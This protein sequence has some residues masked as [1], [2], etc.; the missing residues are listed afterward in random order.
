MARALRQLVDNGIYHVT[1]RGNRREAIFLRDADY[2][3][4]LT[5]YAKLITEHEIHSIAFAL[6]PN[7]V[8]LVLQDPR[9]Q[10]PNFI[11]D[12]HS[13][14]SQYL[15]TQH[16][17][18]GHVFQG[19]YYSGLC[20]SQEQLLTLLRYVHLNPVRAQLVSH[21]CDYPWSSM[22]YYISPHRQTFIRA[23]ILEIF[24]WPHTSA[25][26]AFLD[27]TM[28][29]MDSPQQRLHDEISTVKAGISPHL[30]QSLT[31]IAR[32]IARQHG[33]DFGRIEAKDRTRGVSDER[34]QLIRALHQLQLFSIREIGA[35]LGLK[36]STVHN[37][38]HKTNSGV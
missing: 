17:H 6:M 36:S 16:Q 26:Q 11:R 12:L 25:Q 13:W 34:G 7:H 19:R 38:I 27:F 37:A 1:A 14:Y 3:V 9:L 4:Y 30:P 2:R 33:W 15:N 20:T 18:V 10:L 8:H 31:S 28:S 21:P 23:D 29:G 5:T 35:T 22:K 32:L 24:Q